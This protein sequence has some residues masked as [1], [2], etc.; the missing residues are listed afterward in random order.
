MVLVGMFDA[1]RG[2]R[3]SGR[4]ERLRRRSPASVPPNS[5]KGSWPRSTWPIWGVSCSAAICLPVEIGGTL[6]LVALVGVVADLAESGQTKC[7]RRPKARSRGSTRGSSTRWICREWLAG[8][9]VEPAGQEV[10]HG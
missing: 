8:T 3:V 1:G 10:T 7:R 5:S 2:R 4:V 6:L 9:R